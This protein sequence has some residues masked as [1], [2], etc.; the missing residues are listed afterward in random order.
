MSQVLDVGNKFNGKSMDS[1]IITIQRNLI[2]MEFDIEMINKILYYFNIES[3]DQAIDYLTKNSEGLWSHPFIP[4]LNEEEINDEVVDNKFQEKDKNSSI[5]GEVKSKIKTI[6]NRGI[7]NII[8]YPMSEQISDQVNSFCEIC[9][10]PEKFHVNNN[11]NFLN[12]ENPNQKSDLIE[13]SKVDDNYN[14]NYINTDI[15]LNIENLDNNIANVKNNIIN[16]IDNNIDNNIV[17]NEENNNNECPICLSEIENK[18]ELE[19]C[20]HKFCQE[21]FNNYLMDLINKNSIDN[22]PCPMKSCN[23]KDINEEFF[24]KYLSEEQY[25]KY[26]TFR[27]Q[28]KIA[29]DPKKMFCP[30]CNEYAEI[31]D[32]LKYKYDPNDP[33]YV[34]SILTCINGHQFCSC[35][36]ALHKG[37]CYRDTNDF[38]KFLINEH[39]KQCPKCGFYIK[40]IKGCNH[41][42]CG[43][44]LCKYEFCWLCMKE[45][46]PGH[47]EYGQCKGMQFIDPSGFMY[48]LSRNHPC[49]YRILYVLRSL[50]SLFIIFSVIVL[51]PSVVLIIV[52]LFFLTTSN[53]P[54]K[55][56]I[57]RLN[58]YSKI[59]LVLTLSCI[60]FSLQNLL[61]LILALLIG[62]FII[63]FIF[64]VLFK[65]ARI[66]YRIFSCLRDYI[67]RN[68]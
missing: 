11:N 33:K 47:F 28:N 62:N 22:I 45:A 15:K 30:I 2:D 39:I 48:Q 6:K 20:H 5:I 34:K 67:R 46:V 4:K 49:L 31:E 50:I 14:M 40:K 23:N 64:S 55:E 16:K 42:T 61:H 36:I 8:Y 53:F 27:S 10:E 68:I 1:K 19:T 41:M 13:D 12:N 58:K 35:G 38:Q 24:S 43:N 54:F 51:I 37:D 25:F 3:E 26:R 17:N 21:C 44:A 29:R 57:K 65:C 32:N 52:F 60:I 63:F 9:G 56:K 18:V 7:S 59:L 66:L